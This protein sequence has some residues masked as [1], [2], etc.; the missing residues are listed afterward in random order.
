MNKT[1]KNTKILIVE[2]D[3][4]TRDIYSAVLEK[5]SFE[6]AVAVNG[7]EGLEKALKITPDLILLDICMPVMDGFA[8]LNELRK[9]G[10]YGKNVPVILLTNLSADEENIIKKVVQT[11]PVYYIVKSG[12]SINNLVSKINEALSSK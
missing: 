3:S 9:S 5:S 12:F 11:E 8:M 6:F 2:D 7:K 10:E 1:N 4:A